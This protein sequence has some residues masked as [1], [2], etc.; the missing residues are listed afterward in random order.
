MFLGHQ[1]VGTRVALDVTEAEALVADLER[2]GRLETLAEQAFE[3]PCGNHW[4]MSPGRR[5]LPTDEEGEPPSGEEGYAICEGGEGEEY[6]GWTPF[7]GCAEVLVSRHNE[8]AAVIEQMNE[9][10][11]GPLPSAALT[12]V[13]RH[14]L[15]I[16]AVAAWDVVEGINRCIRAGEPPDLR[17]IRWWGGHLAVAREYV[18]SERAAETSEAESRG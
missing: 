2:L 9:E 8:L 13:E 16:L 4:V 6:L 5:P 17:T 3:E 1:V 11:G 15:P 7:L 12:P 14:S 18:L 10:G